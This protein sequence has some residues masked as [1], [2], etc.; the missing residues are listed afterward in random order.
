MFLW[1]GSN[2]TRLHHSQP[3]NFSAHPCRQVQFKFMDTQG[4]WMHLQSNSYRFYAFSELNDSIYIYLLFTR[5]PSQQSVCNIITELHHRFVIVFDSERNLQH[6]FHQKIELS[7]E[8]FI[9]LSFS[10]VS[11]WLF[12][13]ESKSAQFAWSFEVRILNDHS[14]D[15]IF[16]PCVRKFTSRCVIWIMQ[17]NWRSGPSF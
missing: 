12:S 11:L 7:R 10:T 6:I 14:N 15:G 16:G 8:N 17:F 3:M 4:I 1:K 9:R 5:W 13:H 2:S